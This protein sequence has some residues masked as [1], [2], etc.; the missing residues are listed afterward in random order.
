M[1]A[2]LTFEPHL[3]NFII[4]TGETFLTKVL[5]WQHPR[6]FRLKT[7]SNDALYDYTKS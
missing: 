1:S 6:L 7:I 5:P 3:L 4:I 2:I